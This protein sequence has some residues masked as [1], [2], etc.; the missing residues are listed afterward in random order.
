MMSLKKPCGTDQSKSDS[1]NQYPRKRGVESTTMSPPVAY[2]LMPVPAADSEFLGRM[3][4][5]IWCTSKPLTG[6]FR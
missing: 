2:V 1:S 5:Y 3:S 6:P 4:V